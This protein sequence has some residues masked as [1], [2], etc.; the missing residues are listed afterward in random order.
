MRK[1]EELVAEF[2]LRYEQPVIEELIVGFSGI[3]PPL[4][5]DVLSENVNHEELNNLLGGDDDGHYHLTKERYDKLI[6]LIENPTPQPQPEP[7]PETPTEYDGGF[8]STTEPEYAENIDYWLDG[9]SSRF[10]QEDDE[11]D[12]G[13]SRW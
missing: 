6:E 10:E 7:K 3:D 9:G 2:F 1:Y 11:I 4:K 5:V 8:S 12:G 13:A